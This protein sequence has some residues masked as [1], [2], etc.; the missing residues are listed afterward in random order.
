M[1]LSK[2]QIQIY[3]NESVD[4][5]VAEGLKRRGVNAWSARDGDNLGLTDEE[6]LEY[7]IKKKA[8]IFTHD[9]DFLSLV[10]QSELKHNGVIYVHQQSLSVGECIRRLKTLVETKTNKEMK[11]HVYFL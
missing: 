5:A 7:G 10:T 6:Q 4:V 11:N 1:A 2:Q 8:V 9:D 3:T